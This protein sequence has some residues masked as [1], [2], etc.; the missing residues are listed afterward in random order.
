VERKW[1]EWSEGGGK[2]ARVREVARER[3]VARAR[4]VALLRSA[5]LLRRSCGALAALLRRSAALLHPFSPQPP[6]TSSGSCPVSGCEHSAFVQTFGNVIL[7]PA[8]FVMSILLSAL[9]R[10]REKARWRGIGMVVVGV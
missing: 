9:K 1:D 5:A 3:S 2:V 10:K 7:V 6:L 4:S 8:R